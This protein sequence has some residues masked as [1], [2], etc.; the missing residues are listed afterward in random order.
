M[1]YAG[2]KAGIWAQSFSLW[3]MYPAVSFTEIADLSMSVILTSGTLSPMT[4]FSSELG[5]KFETSMEA[6]HVIDVKS[7]LWA[8][9]ISTGPGN[10][11]LNASYKTADAYDFQEICKIVPGG[12]LVFFPS[13]KLMEKLCTHWRETGQW[14]RLN[15]QKSFFVEPRGSQDEFELTLKDYYDSIRQGNGSAAWKMKKGKKRG[16]K[17]SDVKE[18]QQDPPRVGSSFLAACRGKVCNYFVNL[19]L[20]NSITSSLTSIVLRRLGSWARWR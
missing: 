20:L 9:V 14:S 11:P 19:E 4:S 5:A 7:Q 18:T 10:Q 6:P 12:A 15:A 3:C 1:P 16:L 8:S 13:Y 2:S 17:Q